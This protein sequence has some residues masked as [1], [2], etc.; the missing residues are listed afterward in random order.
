MK[1]T[2]IVKL[3]NTNSTGRTKNLTVPTD[4]IQ[5]V[6]DD[7]IGFVARTTEHS[8]VFEYLRSGA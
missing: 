1:S 7:V 2:T 6:P 5:D 3:K 4:I 8:I